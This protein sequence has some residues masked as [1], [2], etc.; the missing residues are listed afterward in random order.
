MGEHT[1]EIRA[2]RVIAR[3]A[4]TRQ[5]HAV[6]VEN[7]VNSVM[8]LSGASQFSAS[9]QLGIVASAVGLLAM[10]VHWIALP[11]NG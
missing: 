3:S 7:P 8:R 1:A 9:A 11:W 5:S 10:T 4:A 2:P 6:H